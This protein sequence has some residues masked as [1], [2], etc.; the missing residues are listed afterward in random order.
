MTGVVILVA[1]GISDGI[2]ASFWGLTRRIYYKSTPRPHLLNFRTR[3]SYGLG[4]GASAHNYMR[5]KKKELV[6]GDGQGV[7]R[8]AQ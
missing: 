5:P 1:P 6:D 4:P 7:L 2:R 3:I 8:T